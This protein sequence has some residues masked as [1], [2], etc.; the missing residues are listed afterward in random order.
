[1]TFQCWKEKTV[2][3]NGC[4]LFRLKVQGKKYLNEQLLGLS[5]LVGYC[6]GRSP[7]PEMSLQKVL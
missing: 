4:N 5:F 1:M 7:D 3:R 6:R 2:E